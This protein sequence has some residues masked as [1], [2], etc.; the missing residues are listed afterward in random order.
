MALDRECVLN[1]VDDQQLDLGRREQAQHFIGR[2]GL[3]A[4]IVSRRD[5]N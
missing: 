4:R 1:L 5:G 2:Y 3:G